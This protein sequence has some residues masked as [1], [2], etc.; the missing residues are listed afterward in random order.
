MKVALSLPLWPRAVRSRTRRE[1]GITSESD[2]VTSLFPIGKAHLSYRDEHVSARV[3]A[4]RLRLL[5][6]AGRHA[7]LVAR[8]VVQGDDLAANLSAVADGRPPGQA[9]RV[10]DLW[11]CAVVLMGSRARRVHPVPSRAVDVDHVGTDGGS[12]A[13]RARDEQIICRVVAVH[14]GEYCRDNGRIESGHAPSLWRAVGYRAGAGSARRSSRPVAAQR[15]N[16]RAFWCSIS[17]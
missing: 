15:K 12:C 1:K 4:P 17:A 10:F 13:K 5:V 8:T 6:G 7:E 11:S 14:V 2:V 16:N 3:G 9:Q